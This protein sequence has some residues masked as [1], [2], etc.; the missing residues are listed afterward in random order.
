[1]NNHQADYIDDVSIKEESGVHMKG[2]GEVC[3]LF[4]DQADYIDDISIKEESGVHMKGDG[5][6]CTLFIDQ[7]DYKLHNGTFICLLNQVR[8]QT[9]ILIRNMMKEY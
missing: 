9:F 8:F 2:D 7:A 5:E 3:R 4:I 1:M 6:V